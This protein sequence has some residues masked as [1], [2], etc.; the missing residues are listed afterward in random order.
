MNRKKLWPIVRILLIIYVMGGIVL[1]FLQDLII[2]HPRSLPLSHRF[3]F[4]QPFKEV[5]ISPDGK[6]NINILQFFPERS[7]KG[8]V[9]YFHGNMTNIE[10]Y[11]KFASYFTKNDF[12]VW[13]IDYPGYGKTTGRRSEKT[14]YEDALLLYNLATEKTAAENII[15]YGKSL[16]TGVASYLASLK[17]NKKL[18]LETPYY[19]M[20]SMSHNYVPIYPASLLRYNFPTNEYLTKVKSPVIIFHGTDDEVIPYKQSLQLKKKIPGIELITV[21]NGKHNNL[22]EFPAVTQKLDSL[23]TG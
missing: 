19:S 6:R 9:L 17:P 10:R 22:Y 4:S 3:N 23:L 7:A 11:A 1:F 5:N 12:E 13:M 15:I 21:P 8:I 2:F 20:T 14:M 16:G 18:I